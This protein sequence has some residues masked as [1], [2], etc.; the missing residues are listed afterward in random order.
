MKVFSWDLCLVHKNRALS[1][2]FLKRAI[3]CKNWRPITLLNVDNKLSARSLAGQLLKVLHLVIAPDQTC[4]VPGRYIGKNVAFLRDVVC[5]ASETNCPLA[6]LSLDQEKAFDRVDWSFSYSTLTRMGFGSS[7]INWVR[8][9]YT[10]ISSSALVNGY[11]TRAFKPSRGVRQGCPL[12]QLLYILTMEV[13]AVNVGKNLAIVGL[14]IPKSPRLPV[15]SLYA[16]DTSAVVSSDT[17]ILTVFE[18]YSQFER[19]SGSRIN[20]KKC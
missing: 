11:Q 18:V 6:I 7:F 12:S 9:L 8:L 14:R 4:G 3:D 5:Y 13:I 15:L 19:A 17:A 1:L 2:W 16:D 10:D 20:L